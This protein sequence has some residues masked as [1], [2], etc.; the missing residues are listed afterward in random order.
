MASTNEEKSAIQQEAEDAALRGDAPKV[1]ECLQHGASLWSNA[2]TLL[3]LQNG[4]VE[5]YKVLLDAGDDVNRNMG[6]IGTPLVSALRHNHEP[7]LEFLFSQDLDV[8]MGGFGT[9]LPTVSVA[10]RYAHDIKWLKAILDRGARLERTGALHVAA[11]LGY[12]DRMQMLL[13]YGADVNEVP[14]MKV[15]AFFSH[16]K[17]P[18]PSYSTR[19][20]PLHWAIAGG[21]VAAVEMLLTRQPDLDVMNE[22]EVSA[23]QSLDAF[24]ISRA[25]GC[26]S[27]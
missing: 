16:S 14:F 20:T 2:I 18:K 27:V 15:V 6:Y 10:V 22:E 21:S 24:R 26:F 25:E 17:K 3:A 1:R 4:D 11:Y 7:L 19:G 5:T 9:W 13:D 12:V 8:N 23:G